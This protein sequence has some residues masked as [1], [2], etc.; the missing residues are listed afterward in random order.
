MS[1]VYESRANLMT[2]KKQLIDFMLSLYDRGL[3][4]K[5]PEEFDYEW[6]VWDYLK[7][8]DSDALNESPDVNEQEAQKEV[9]PRCHG[10][11]L[12]TN[13]HGPVFY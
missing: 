5:S 7:P 1:K 12:S 9:C 4:I 8:T 10:R 3:L 11:G 2:M 13:M 6:V